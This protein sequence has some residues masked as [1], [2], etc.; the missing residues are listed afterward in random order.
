VRAGLSFAALLQNKGSV[1][2]CRDVRASSQLIE[3]ALIS[4]LLA[5]GV[6]AVECGIVPTPAMLFAI[7]RLH[8]S[9]GVSVTGSLTPASTT[10]LLFFLDDTG[11]MSEREEQRFEELFKA[12]HL[13]RK[14]WSEVGSQALLTF[15]KRTLKSYEKN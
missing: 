12:E 11:E 2:V 1:L 14:S 10:G 13:T 6:D 8:Y 7:K 9:G 3:N 4:G 5:G 15:Q